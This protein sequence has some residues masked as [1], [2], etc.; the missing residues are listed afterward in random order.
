MIKRFQQTASSEAFEHDVTQVQA[1]SPACG[2]FAEHVSG[3]SGPE[4]GKNEVNGQ[5]CVPETQSC[6]DDLQLK[7]GQIAELMSGS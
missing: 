3:I 4:A 7:S 6:Q 2:T 1:W 5:V